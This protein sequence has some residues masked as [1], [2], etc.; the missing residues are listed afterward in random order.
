M[1]AGLAFGWRW[2][3]PHVHV[4]VVIGQRYNHA[5]WSMKVERRPR[6]DVL[7]AFGDETIKE[8]LGEGDVN[9]RWCNRC[10]LAEVEPWVGD[11][12]VEPILVRG[13]A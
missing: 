10:A 7:N 6:K 3:D 2:V 4:V 8:I 9:I 1:P 11:V 13:V 12:Y 5:A